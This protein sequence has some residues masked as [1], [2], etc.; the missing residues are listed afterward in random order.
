MW[1]AE[2]WNTQKICFN[3]TEIKKFTYNFGKFTDL[4][5]PTQVSSGILVPNR[6]RI[7]NINITIEY[8]WLSLCWMHGYS[9]N[10]KVVAF[11]P[12]LLPPLL[13][14]RSWIVHTLLKEKDGIEPLANLYCS[15]TEY[16]KK[17]QILEREDMSLMLIP[18]TSNQENLFELQIF[19]LKFPCFP[20][21]LFFGSCNYLRICFEYCKVMNKF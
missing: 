5:K 10:K 2:D 12:Y 13:V 21:L 4:L 3:Y 15:P 19:A 20:Q 9:E 1:N 11:L 8:S 18:A 7:P 16:K 17:T 6:S 14:A